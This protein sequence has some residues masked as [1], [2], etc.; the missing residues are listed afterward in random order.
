MKRVASNGKSFLQRLKR[1][2][3]DAVFNAGFALV[4]HAGIV[5]ND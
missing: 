2:S 5:M 1:R 4:K 3:A